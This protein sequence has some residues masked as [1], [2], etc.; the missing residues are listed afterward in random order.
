MTS[1]S[2]LTILEIMEFITMSMYTFALRKQKASS[3]KKIATF[4][5]N[6]ENKKLLEDFE[7]QSDRSF[8]FDKVTGS[9]VD[10]R[11]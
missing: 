4:P 3:K 5:I 7:Q 8:A 9:Y 10:S 11:L 2:I 6:E 1:L